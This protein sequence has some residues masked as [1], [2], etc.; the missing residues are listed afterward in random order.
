MKIEPDSTA[1][2]VALWRAMHKLIDSPPH[3][4]DDEVGLKLIAP[5]EDWQARPDMHPI[6]TRIY[7]ASIVSRARFIEDLVEEKFRNEGITQYIM[8]GAGLDTFAQRRADL[9]SKLNVFEI[10]KPSAQAWKKERLEKFGFGVPSYLHLVPVDFEVNE[11]WVEK[12]KAHGLDMKKP[13]LITSTGVTLYLTREAIV[14]M[15]K[16]V[17]SF[18]AQTTFAMTFMLPAEMVPEEER[19]AYIAVQ[20]RARASGTPFLSFFPPEEML[21]MARAAGFKSVK[22]VSTADIK[23][24]F[25]KN[26]ADGLMPATGE[27]FLIATT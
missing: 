19:A 16:Q 4:I 27:E 7:R 18:P 24:R 12:L 21:A 15:L 17:A 10:D 23:E 13:S 2:R 14:L 6:G 25:F 22:H 5:N 8:L 1:V 20:E 11:S 26:R 9:A 3:I